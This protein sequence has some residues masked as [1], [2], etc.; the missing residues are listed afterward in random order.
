MTSEIMPPTFACVS[1]LALF[2][3]VC[4]CWNRVAQFEQSDA[5]PITGKWTNVEKCLDTNKPP[6][7][8]KMKAPSP[9][10]HCRRATVRKKRDKDRVFVETSCQGR[11]H[12]PCENLGK[13]PW[14]SQC[15]RPQTRVTKGR[16]HHEPRRKPG[17]TPGDNVKTPDVMRLSL[18]LPGTSPAGRNPQCVHHFGRDVA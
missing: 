7:I 10:L 5:D 6:P 17:H 14:S 8:P 4:L 11:T 18:W 15:A 1:R 13:H 3:Q 9:S 2:S 16:T 12:L